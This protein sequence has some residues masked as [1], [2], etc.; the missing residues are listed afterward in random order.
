[1]KLLSKLN[2]AIVW[3]RMKAYINNRLEGLEIPVDYVVERGVDGPWKYK[4]YASGD[5]ELW[6][7]VRQYA[8]GTASGSSTLG[9][10]S[11]ASVNIPSMVKTVENVSGWAGLGAAW[12]VLSGWGYT[13]AGVLTLHVSGNNNTPTDVRYQLTIKGTW[14]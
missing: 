9:Y 12:G 10:D 2:L 7:G 14:K 5:I 3:A 6:N 4:K 11:V 13:T 1:M 8:T